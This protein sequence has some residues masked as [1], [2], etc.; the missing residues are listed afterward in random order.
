MPKVGSET[1]PKSTQK[2]APNNI[3]FLPKNSRNEPNLPPI[4]T[5]N[6][7]KKCSTKCKNEHPDRQHDPTRPKPYIPQDSTKMSPKRPKLD[8][9]LTQNALNMALEDPKLS[10]V[11]VIFS[12]LFPFPIL[13]LLRLL[14]VS[15]LLFLFVFL[16][17]SLFS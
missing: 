10:K 3:T 2:E 11:G 13:L 1:I 4:W 12:R 9:K 5:Q 14:L 8:P 6:C 15:V 17:L 7:S 16:L